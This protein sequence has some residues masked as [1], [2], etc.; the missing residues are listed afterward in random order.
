MALIL[1]WSSV[2]TKN[3]HWWRA[4]VERALREYPALAE[5]KR[6]LQASSITPNYSPMPGSSDPSRTTETLALRQL[7][8]EEERWIAAIEKAREDMKLRSDG[9]EILRLVSM[10]FFKQTHTMTGA[11][12]ETHVS[13]S[14]AQRRVGQ[15]IARVAE[16]KGLL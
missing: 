12:I 14:T 10:V 2:A 6:A 3:K 16:H 15:F 13:L 8:D 9:N 5:R 7:S 11:A 1:R 4:N